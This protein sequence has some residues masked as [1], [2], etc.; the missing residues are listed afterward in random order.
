M[1]KHYGRKADLQQFIYMLKDVAMLYEAINLSRNHSRVDYTTLV[2]TKN[3]T[4]GSQE[5]AC[6]GGACLI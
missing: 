5:V 2:E 1:F 6:A 3:S 4:A